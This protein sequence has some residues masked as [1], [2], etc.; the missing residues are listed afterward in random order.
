MRLG[1][2]V[3]PFKWEPPYEDAVRRIARLG[4]RAVELIA[5]KKEFLEQYYTAETI[6]S[7]RSVLDG[8]G[9]LLSQFV[10]CPGDDLASPDPA[11]R[12]AAVAYFKRNVDV[13]AELGASIVNSITHFP[14]AIEYPSLV[15]RVMT[16]VFTVKVP[17]NLDW[18]QNWLDY[19][20]SIRQCAQY[21]ESMGL[22]YSLEMHPFRYAANT[23]G[24]LRLIEAVDSPV[25]GANFDP[26]HT[27]PMG[28]MTHVAIYRLADRL[29]HC[30]FSDNDGTTNMH[31]R[32]GKGKIDW[33]SAMVALRDI[34]YDYV[35]SLE[36]EDIPGVSRGVNPQA[37]AYTANPVASPEV[38]REYRLALDYIS[39]LADAAG[40]KVE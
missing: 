8:E 31:F 35:V 28:D 6:K 19:V 38:D 5:W 37:G 18:R 11:R 10:A 16:Q 13:G 34:G 12:A 20:G 7:L 15:S 27:F 32:P 23:E 33:D 1:A 39:G 29:W 40:I 17:G 3:W 14:F 22:K 2:P 26:S 36:F 24:L 21:A 30:D 4:F 25:L 9:L